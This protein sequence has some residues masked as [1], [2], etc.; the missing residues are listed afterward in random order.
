MT[1]LSQKI[2]ALDT[3]IDGLDSSTLQTQIDTNT[4]D[5]SNLQIDKQDKL[6]QGTGISIDENN[7]IS[8]TGG[9]GTTIDSTTDLSCKTLTTVGNATIGG[10]ISAPNQISFRA[11]RS[12]AGVVNSN[13]ILP[14]NDVITNIGNAY[15]VS[16]YHFTAP[17]N[18]TYYFFTSFFTNGDNT[19]TVDILKLSGST[20]SILY[21]LDRPSGQ[22]GGTRDISASICAFINSGEK[23][24]VKKVGNNS[25]LLPNNPFCFFGGCLL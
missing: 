1:S 11:S 12:G 15:D 2:S 25:I 10:I 17:V 21:R 4:T 24:Y 22:A 9:S 3:K 19:Y 8:S 16:T 6:T 23:V 7:V 13:I 18:G 20:E 14:F 5:I